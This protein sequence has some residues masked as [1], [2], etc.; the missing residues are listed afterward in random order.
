[1]QLKF[2][3]AVTHFW[4]PLLILFLAFIS[5]QKWYFNPLAP[6]QVVTDGYEALYRIIYRANSVNVSRLCSANVSSL[7]ILLLLG[8]D[9]ELNP[10]DKWPSCGVCSNQV[11]P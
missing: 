6:K 10:G 3:M 5:M 2:T 9:I 7:C 4:A 1:M 11:K 8:G